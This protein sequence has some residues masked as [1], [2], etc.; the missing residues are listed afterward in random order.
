MGQLIREE[1]PFSEHHFP[2]PKSPH[3]FTNSR[4]SRRL[5]VGERT[6]SPQTKVFPWGGGVPANRGA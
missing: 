6:Q 3:H 4:A 1:K 5:G 2:P